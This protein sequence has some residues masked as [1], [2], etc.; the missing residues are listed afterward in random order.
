MITIKVFYE[1]TDLGSPKVK[2]QIDSGVC[3]QQ[4][5]QILIERAMPELSEVAR[6]YGI[7]FD[8]FHKNK[9]TMVLTDR[10]TWEFQR[11]NEQITYALHNLSELI[12]PE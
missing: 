9:V 11:E 2:L 8:W 1:T 6:R 7:D 3:N 4:E 5:A 12:V 10:A